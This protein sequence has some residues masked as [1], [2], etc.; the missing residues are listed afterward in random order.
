MLD[1]RSPLRIGDAGEVPGPRAATVVADEDAA[2]EAQARGGYRCAEI[3]ID[4]P[5]RRDVYRG[6]G[7][8]DEERGVDAGAEVIR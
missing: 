6:S 7:A 1:A 2:L 3:G 5:V 4:G 8:K